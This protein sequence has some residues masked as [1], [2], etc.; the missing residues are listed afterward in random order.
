MKKI[1]YLLILTFSL[2][3]CK[4]DPETVF[5]GESSSTKYQ[6]KSVTDDETTLYFAYNNDGLLLTVNYLDDGIDPVSI[7]YDWQDDLLTTYGIYDNDTSVDTF[8]RDL[9]GYVLSDGSTNFVYNAQHQIS[10]V[11][12]SGSTKYFNWSGGNII[13]DFTLNANQ[14]TSYTSVYSYTT[15]NEMRDFG[16]NYFVF[17]NDFT[18]TYDSKKLPD[19]IIT[20]N[21]ATGVQEIVHYEYTFDSSGKVISE[22]QVTQYL[23]T[24][25]NLSQGSTYTCTFAY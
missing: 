22:T 5:G 4:K 2:S 21:H 16:L 6:V 10:S 3:A 11:L 23:D 13:S 7:E 1:V 24:E 15:K 8:L 20:N 25:G 14:D 12:F 17:G 18:Y 19:V 9:S